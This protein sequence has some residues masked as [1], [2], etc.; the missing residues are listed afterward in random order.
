MVLVAVP[1]TA[2]TH[3]YAAP[4][5][6]TRALGDPD[7]PIYLDPAYPPEERA[8]DLVARMTVEEKASQMNSSQSEIP[9][10]EGTRVEYH[11]NRPDVVAVGP[12]GV[13]RA[14]GSGVATITATVRYHGGTASGKF[15]VGV[16]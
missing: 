8:I 7:H 9:L 13:P 3:G 10:P 5:G 14:A 6:G 16:R 4:T 15:S 12:D 11:S 2:P 1:A